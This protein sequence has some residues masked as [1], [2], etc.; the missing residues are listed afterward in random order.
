M[1]LQEKKATRFRF[2]NALY[3]ETD[4]NEACL[5]DMWE[6]G[7]RLGLDQRQ[8]DSAVEYLK[9]EYLLS[10]ETMGGHVAI[11]HAGVLE[12]EEAMSDP[13]QPTEHFPAAATINVITIGTMSGGTVQQ[14]GSHSTQTVT[15]NGVAD[16]RSFLEALKA[17]VGQLG[18]SEQDTLDI[19]V[20]VETVEAQLKHSSPKK[21]IVDECLRSI[22]AVL[23]GGAGG[24]LGNAAPDLLT[25]LGQLLS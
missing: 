9:G 19:H 3:E 17:N 18:L 6:L 8:T 1:S 13:T 22:Q 20:E 25:R 10:I 16:I 15:T 7:E 21:K 23:L 24:A 12:I 5:V 4:G 14:A 2:L 11:T